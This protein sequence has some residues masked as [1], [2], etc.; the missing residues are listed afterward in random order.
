MCIKS[1]YSLSYTNSMLVIFIVH[2]IASYSGQLWLE[3]GG[4]GGEEPSNLLSFS[5][6]HVDTIV[7]KLSHTGSL[8]RY[9]RSVAVCSSFVL[10]F[11]PPSCASAIDL[12]P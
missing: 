11:S 2:G 6:S 12:N 5:L 8:V 3:G 4:V 7:V 10:L 1:V 9:R